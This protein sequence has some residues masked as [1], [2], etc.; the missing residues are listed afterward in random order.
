MNLDLLKKELSRD[1]GRK[2]E[3]YRDSLGLWTVGVGHMVGI[4]KRILKLTEPEIDAFLEWDIEA[5]EAVATECIPGFADLDEVRQRAVV[6][7]AF[8]LG[9]RLAGFHEMIGAL[10]RKDFQHAADA[11]MDSKWAKQVGDRAG[12]IEYMLRTGVAV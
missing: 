5:A 10:A 8:N 7:M 3:A 6:N 9:M 12:R 11:A 2:P 1:E 4:Q